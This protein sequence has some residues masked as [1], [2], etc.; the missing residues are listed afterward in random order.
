MS[1]Y[2]L[3]CTIGQVLQLVTI[4]TGQYQITGLKQSREQKVAM[5]TTVTSM[6]TVIHGGFEYQHRISVVSV[7]QLTFGHIYL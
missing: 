5:P 2:I 3:P 1:L 7:C 6:A 4:E